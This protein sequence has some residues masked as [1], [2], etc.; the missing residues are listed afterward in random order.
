MNRDEINSLLLYKV[1]RPN[2]LQFFKKVVFGQSFTTSN[3]LSIPDSVSVALP[4]EARMF[5]GLRRRNDTKTARA[6]TLVLNDESIIEGAGNNLFSCQ[7]GAGET[8]AEYIEL[9]RKLTGSDTM[10][11]HINYG[12][13][14]N[15]TLQFFIAVDTRA[16]PK[17]GTPK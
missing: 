9:T 7:Q 5:F 8:D 3:D 14:S 6:C 1:C 10:T 17:E 2:E 13:Q 11:Y 16:M 15:E 4:Q 12:F